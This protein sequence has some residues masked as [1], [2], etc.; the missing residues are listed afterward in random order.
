MSKSAN[1]PARPRAAL[2]KASHTP[3]RYTGPS[4]EEILAMRREYLNPGI[5]LIYKV[6]VCIVEG[7][8]QYLWDEKGKQYLDAFGG[9]VTVSVGHCHP[10]I[11]ERIRDQ[12]G[13]LVHATTI[14]LHPTI[15]QFGKALAD[16]MPQGSGLKVT[17]FT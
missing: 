6:P 15:A 2:P 4:R 17:Y 13:R 10:K 7:P 14:Y 1:T 12:A 16:H 5:F 3:T 11:T 8:M 9:I